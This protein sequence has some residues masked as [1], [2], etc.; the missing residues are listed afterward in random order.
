M[1]KLHQNITIMTILL[2]ILYFVFLIILS[3]SMAREQ[4]WFAHF[5]YIGFGLFAPL[6]G[7]LVWAT[8]WAPLDKEVAI[9]LTILAHLLFAGILIIS[10]LAL[11]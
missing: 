9:R 5:F 11:V 4:G 1:L 8:F 2:G 6:V 7:P 3:R 10:F